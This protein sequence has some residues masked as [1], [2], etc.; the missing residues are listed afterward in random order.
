MKLSNESKMSQ[1]TLEDYGREIL[2]NEGGSEKQVLA[3]ILEELEEMR[4]RL[5]RLEYKVEYRV[6]SRRR[7]NQYQ[8]QVVSFASGEIERFYKLQQQLGLKILPEDPST[9]KPQHIRAFVAELCNIT[10]RCNM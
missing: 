9:L 1:R 8:R 4:E 3:N 6:G 7:K 5:S 10:L 2:T